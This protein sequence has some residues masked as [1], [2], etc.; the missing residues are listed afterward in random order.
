MVVGSRENNIGHQVDCSLDNMAEGLDS[1]PCVVEHWVPQQ[2]SVLWAVVDF[3][4][5]VCRTF[6]WAPVVVVRMN[7]RNVLGMAMADK[8]LVDNMDPGT[9]STSPADV[10]D[11]EGNNLVHMSD[12][13]F[14]VQV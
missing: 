3:V 6:H 10:A 4:V 7:K 2:L 14:G 1:V 13:A 9:S 8:V 11:K 12:N 5:E